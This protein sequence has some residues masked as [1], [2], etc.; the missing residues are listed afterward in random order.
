[1]SAEQELVLTANWH[2]GKAGG[3]SENL[4]G[5]KAYYSLKWGEEVIDHREYTRDE[6]EAE[7]K[8][9]HRAGEDATD[10]EKALKKFSMQQ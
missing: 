10:H 2:V 1:M 7:I 5:P 9:L 4:D 6:L 3:P 8:R